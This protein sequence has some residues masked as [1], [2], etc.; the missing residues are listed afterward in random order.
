MSPGS[1]WLLNCLRVG[2]FSPPHELLVA[3]FH[4]L[5]GDKGLNVV[6]I[7]AKQ[8]ELNYKNLIPLNIFIVEVE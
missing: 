5:A 6:C 2:R 7:N 8:Y 4:H 1:G 3:I